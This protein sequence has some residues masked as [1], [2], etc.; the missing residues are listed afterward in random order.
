[1]NNPSFDKGIILILSI[2]RVI[3]N[4]IPNN[5]NFFNDLHRS[6]LSFVNFLLSDI[7]IIFFVKKCNS[8]FINSFYL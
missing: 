5:F 7:K 2:M 6:G 8:V 3:F 4:T 1:M